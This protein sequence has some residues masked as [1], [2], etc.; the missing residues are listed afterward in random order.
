MAAARFPV[1]RHTLIVFLPQV[2][3][4]SASKLLQKSPSTKTVRNAS[5]HPDQLTTILD[6]AL[7]VFQRV[8]HLGYTTCII[9]KLPAAGQIGIEI[10]TI[11]VRPKT[12]VL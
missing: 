3:K 1:P 5:A 12:P 4:R 2:M 9:P 11:K 7:V 8:T 6:N 10:E